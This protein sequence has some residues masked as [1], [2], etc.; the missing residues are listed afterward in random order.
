MYAYIYVRPN[1][2]LLSSLVAAS[3]GNRSQTSLFHNV[4][5][6]PTRVTFIS[7][8]LMAASY[9]VFSDS[10][11]ELQ[12]WK[13]KGV[14]VEKVTFPSHNLSARIPEM[15]GFVFFSFFFACFLS[16]IISAL[17]DPLTPQRK[18]ESEGTQSCP[19]LCEPLDC[20]PPGSSV[21][22]I[23]QARVLEWVA[24]S[25]SRGSSW[26]R[27]RTW[28]SGITGRLFTI[29]ATRDKMLRN[30]ICEPAEA[31]GTQTPLKA[32]QWDEVAG[33]HY[34]PRGHCTQRCVLWP[35]SLFSSSGFLPTRSVS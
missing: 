9:A 1:W 16:C 12:R 26:P 22:G 33:V 5:S 10:L 31:P 17:F 3:G 4:Y 29:W 25:F 21:H 20:S 18:K 6:V 27:D 15:S 8:H 13:L 19:T 23:F 14:M 28:V 24:I 11:T 35:G 30:M 7:N 2:S 34:I 32:V